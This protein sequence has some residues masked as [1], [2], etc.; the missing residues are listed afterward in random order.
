[1][2]SIVRYV[3]YLIVSILSISVLMYYLLNTDIWDLYGYNLGF[4]VLISSII[5]TCYMFFHEMVKPS[6][7]GLAVNQEG[8]QNVN[9]I[10]RNFMVDT[11]FKYLFSFSLSVLIFYI[12]HALRTNFKYVDLYPSNWYYIAD[13]YVNLILPVFH[14]CE[15]MMTNRYRHRHVIA[16]FAVLFIICFLHCAYKVIIRSLYYKDYEIVFPT[17]A[18]YILIFLI[19]M[20]GYAF[21]DFSLYRKINPQG[22]YALFTA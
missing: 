21:Y 10:E 17:I 5:Y 2:G 12:I 9:I 15:L 14:L 11:Y 18:D 22:N 3:T 1:M 8:A 19:A 16:D 7:E 4:L 20:N 13:M 6:E